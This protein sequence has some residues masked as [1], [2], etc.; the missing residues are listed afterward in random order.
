M[1]KDLTSKFRPIYIVGNSRSGTTLMADILR[2]H[3]DIFVFHELHFFENLWTPADTSKVISRSKGV[4]LCARLL[5]IQENGYRARHDLARYTDRAKSIIA[6]IVTEELTTIEV[7]EALLKYVTLTNDRAFLAEKTPRNVFYIAEILELFPGARIINMIR[8]PRD[9]LASQKNKWKRHSRRKD[10]RSLRESLRLGMNYHPITTSK[11]WNAS[12]RAAE[13]FS[14][15]PRVFFLRFEDLIFQP[16]RMLQKVC[17]FL[18]V[19]LHE[20]MMSVRKMA[21]SF[22]FDNLNHCGFDSKTVERWKSTLRPSELYYCQSL[23]RDEMKRYGYSL[24]HVSPGTLSL[25]LPLITLPMKLGASFL[26]NLNR[27]AKVLSSIKR[28]FPQV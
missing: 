13:R 14:Q 12:V 25:T 17:D 9:V 23:N 26:L 15:D 4:R 6:T 20:S 27:Y 7:Y 16:K 18:E 8:D 5:S 24:S 1:T 3:H 10:L 28:R 22:E 2:K 21:S 11:L 19:E